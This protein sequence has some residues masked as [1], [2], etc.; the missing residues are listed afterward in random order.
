M[1]AEA[2]MPALYRIADVLALPS[3]HE[4]FGLA[5]LEALASGTPVV[6][7]RRAPFTE[8]LGP[9]L[10]TLADPDSRRR[11]RAGIARALATGRRRRARGLRSR[12]GP[13]WAQVAARHAEPT[14]G[15]AP[16]PEMHFDV[17]WPD[18]GETR[19]YS[20]S[21]IVRETCRSGSTTRCPSSCPQPHDVNIGSERVRAKYGYACSAALDQ[22]PTSNRARRRSRRPANPRTAFELPKASAS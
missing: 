3:L 1:V 6:V 22:L 16:M 5:V 20:P 17:R 15:C 12:P 11:H 8:Y 13:R 7:S 21:L 19:C 2:D 9:V 14:K 18:G 10:P 4:G